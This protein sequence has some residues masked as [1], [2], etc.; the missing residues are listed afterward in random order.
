M[1]AFFT[2][3]RIRNTS[4]ESIFEDYLHWILGLGRFESLRA[5]RE[6]TGISSS[7]HIDDLR[8]SSD[9][10]VD[11]KTILSI[12]RSHGSTG[13]VGSSQSHDLALLRL[14]QPDHKS[15]LVTWKN[16]IRIQGEGD[17]TRI[18][19][20]IG[21]SN[22]G[23]L[24]LSPRFSVPHIIRDLL[25]T[26]AASGIEPSDLHARQIRCRD[27]EETDAFVQHVLLSSSRS[28]PIVLLSPQ[29]R[30]EEILVDP[31][32][33]AKTLQGMATV[34][35]LT[36]RECSQALTRALERVHLDPQYSCFDG[37]V[38]L[39]FPQISTRDA[40]YRHPLWTRAALLRISEESERRNQL[41]SG[42]LAFRIASATLPSDL[43]RSIEAFD[44][45]AQRRRIDEVTSAPM[46]DPATSMENFVEK[47]TERVAFLK[48]EIGRANELIQLIE[49]DNQDKIKQL[50]DAGRRIEELEYEVQRERLK[51]E[52]LERQI[53][54]KREIENARNASLLSEDVRSALAVVLRSS[55]DPTP[56]ESL[57]LVAA[58]WP[59][60][61][62][63][64]ESALKSAK[65]SSKFKYGRAATE[66][67]AKLATDYYDVIRQS[68]DVEAKKIFGKNEFSALESTP[69]R[70]RESAIRRRTF[71]YK[72]NPTLMLAHLKIGSK[73]SHT[74]TLRIHFHWDPV[75]QRIVIGH[76]GPHLDFD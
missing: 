54:T 2:S 31:D 42:L 32:F 41:I 63:V 61:L 62:I 8:T 72:G 46:P 34:T 37:G 1:P 64:L 14:S 19:H 20:A 22:R 68:G 11:G 66:L 59:D 60:R 17:D 6:R 12:R 13:S 15:D 52:T 40:I 47:A 51:A 25:S 38:R 16:L 67:L 56:E 29:T 44:R 39:Y 48:A 18:E 5:D 57:R 75:E 76:C 53:E 74:E 65:K 4:P 33:V 69:V 30:N 71:L 50:E 36:S 26:Y 27:L 35:T 58:T 3:L 43:P 21:R 24:Q 73:D 55:K 23:R 7:I 49:D 9:H 70:S 10:D 45:A 28:I